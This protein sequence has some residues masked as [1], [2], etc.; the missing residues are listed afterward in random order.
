MKSSL[1]SFRIS[2][3]PSTIPFHISA[4]NDKRFVEGDY[5]T[6][7]IDN[8]KTYIDKPGEMIAAFF[9]ELPKKIEFIKS[10]LKYED[11][12]WMRDRLNWVS[13]FDTY[14]NLSKWK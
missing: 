9:S 10:D 4:L 2:G 14:T 7:F 8:M 13:E 11:D 6:S 1:L 12:K 3:V 5:D